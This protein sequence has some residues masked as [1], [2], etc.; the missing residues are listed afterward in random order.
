MKVFVS[1]SGKDSEFAKLLV[2]LIQK[3]MRLSSNDIRCSSVDGYRLPGGAST[4]E[5][6]RNEVHD[7]SVLIGLITSNSLDSMYVAFELGARW[8][9][10]KPM[11]P[12]LALGATT[13][14][15]EGPLAGI[16]VLSCDNESQI[17]Q[18][19][20]EIATH[21]GITYESTSSYFAEVRNLVQMSSGRTIT[22]DSNHSAGSPIPESPDAIEPVLT[23]SIN[24]DVVIRSV[25]QLSQ[26]NQLQFYRKISQQGF[27]QQKSF[28]LQ[29]FT[30]Q[31]PHI[32]LAIA[33]GPTKRILRPAQL[34]SPDLSSHLQSIALQGANA[35][36]SLREGIDSQIEND[37]LVLM[38]ESRYARLYENGSITYAT[39]FGKASQLG[40]ST[41]VEE[42]VIEQI[43]KFLQFA[44]DMLDYVDN[45]N[46]LS[47][48]GV[49]TI[50]IGAEYSDWKTRSEY[51][52]D[53]NT[54]SIP[55]A[56][57][58]HSM[59]PVA[60]PDPITRIALN[61]YSS[62]LAEDLTIQLR[63]EFHSSPY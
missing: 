2:D 51:N 50:L 62:Q 41:I 49:A 56:M 57:S 31:A 35:P 39:V 3:S 1:H 22:K 24:S 54:I 23:E 60:L 38:Q 40:L 36:F 20:E 59:K 34:E 19:I 46:H 27:R 42:D 47:H 52:Q 53:P 26:L 17:I 13:D 45:A 4:D 12:L 8:G 15:L 63:R 29:R 16:N 33:S 18:A 9:A 43:S 32:A 25:D 11:L 61:S 6:L 14:H 58:S 55:R 7:A 30:P 5:Q 28:P 21:L 44:N 37:A 48:F 10:G